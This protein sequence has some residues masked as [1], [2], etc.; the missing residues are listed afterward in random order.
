MANLIDF[1]SWLSALP[2]QGYDRDW[3]RRNLPSLERAWRETRGAPMQPSPPPPGRAVR[4]RYEE[5]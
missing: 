1:E 3:I 2:K 5:L 4:D